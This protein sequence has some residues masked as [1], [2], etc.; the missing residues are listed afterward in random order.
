MQTIKP[1]GEHCH[2]P[3]DPCKCADYYFAKILNRCD[4]TAEVTFDYD[5]WVA[6]KIHC[7]HGTWVGT[8]FGLCGGFTQSIEDAWRKM[9][10]DHPP[11]EE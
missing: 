1:H 5:M 6:C 10:K 9:D 8:S 11:P 2:H 4:W 3:D 7:E